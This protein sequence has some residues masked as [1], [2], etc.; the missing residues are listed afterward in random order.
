[1]QL[2]LVR[3]AETLWNQD[4]R[5]QG[6]TDVPLSRIGT[7]RVLSGAPYVKSWVHRITRVY[8][9]DL[10]RAKTTAEGLFPGWENRMTVEPR[11]R[12]IHLGD[13]EGQTRD[14]IMQSAL[15]RFHAFDEMETVSAPGGESFRD[16]RE[17]VLSWY[18]DEVG[19]WGDRD[20]VVVVAHGGTIRALL[21]A[22]IPGLPGSFRQYFRVGNLSVSVLQ[23]G[24][25]DRIE[26]A[27]WNVPIEWYRGPQDD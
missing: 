20:H 27:H 21:F 15:D 1:M 22:L 2:I 23:A 13:W 6:H 4:G 9:S 8:T 3:H 17:R 7:V 24:R 5:W 16:S 19:Q 12:E 14:H 10:S 11:L 25:P 26:V 18:Q